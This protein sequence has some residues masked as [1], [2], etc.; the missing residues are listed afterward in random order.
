MQIR[1]EEEAWNFE[2][3]DP[4]VAELLRELPGSAVP[5]DDKSRQ[6]VFTSPTAGADEEADEEWRE[7][8]EPEL[9]ELFQ[10]HVDVVVGDLAGMKTDRETSSLRIPDAN[11]RAW[12][13]TLN[14]AR[15][16]LGAK[17]GVTDADTAGRR[18]N[19]QPAKAYA[20]LQIDFYGMLLSLLLRH[21]E[22]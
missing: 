20:L 22:L 13:H 9:R 1:R 17:H 7:N 4:F 18:K 10:S 11:S 19:R 6:R 2:E 15:L 16:A 12:I 21:T 8:V 5:D 14:Q 3:M